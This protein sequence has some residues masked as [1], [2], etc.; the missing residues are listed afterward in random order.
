ME[1]VVD[2]HR[3][4]RVSAGLDDAPATPGLVGW[5]FT[6]EPQLHEVVLA[7]DSRRDDAIR[8]G[9]AVVA[10]GRQGVRLVLGA[11]DGRR[12]RSCRSPGRRGRRRGRRRGLGRC[13][14]SDRRR[15]L[16]RF[17]EASVVARALVTLTQIVMDG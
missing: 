15:S 17:D 1:E 4:W 6:E 12:G 10:G 5:S 7:E 13:G 11:A 2:A 3:R 14:R 8:V 16:L 9:V